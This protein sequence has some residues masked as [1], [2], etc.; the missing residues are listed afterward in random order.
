MQEYRTD[1]TDAFDTLYIG[2]EKFP[3]HDFMGDLSEG[4]DKIAEYYVNVCVNGGGDFNCCTFV[5]F[6]Y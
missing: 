1:G 4:F 3:Q 5:A 6:K 2:C